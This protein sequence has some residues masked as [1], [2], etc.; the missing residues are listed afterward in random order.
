MDIHLTK[1][2][3]NAPKTTYEH[4]LSL[5]FL[6]PSNSQMTDITDFTILNQ[7]CCV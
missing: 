3:N 1:N 2:K 5:E 4:W 6:K 7:F